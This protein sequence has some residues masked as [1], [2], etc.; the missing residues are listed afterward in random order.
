MEEQGYIV[1]YE[2]GNFQSGYC[3]VK[4]RKIVVVNK[5]FETEAR[6]NCLID[7]MKEM[8]IEEALFTEKSAKFYQQLKANQT[9]GES[10]EEELTTP[11]SIS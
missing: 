4:D 9:E 8:N 2:K 3:I 5:F 6:S 10:S 1:R 11:D 7:V